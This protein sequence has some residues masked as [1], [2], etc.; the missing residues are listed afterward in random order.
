MDT[1][2]AIDQVAPHAVKLFASRVLHRQD[3][4]PRLAFPSF[5]EGD[6]SK[7][8]RYELVYFITYS[9]AIALILLGYKLARSEGFEPIAAGAGAASFMLIFPVMQSFGGY[10]YD[11]IELAFFCLF[12]L[13][14]RRAWW[15]AMLVVTVLATW[16]K[17]SFFFFAVTAYP[18]LRERKSPPMS[19]A[20]T[21]GCVILAGLTYEV[22]RI[23]FGANAGDTAEYHLVDQ[24]YYFLSGIFLVKWEIT[25]GV[26]LPHPFSIPWIIAITALVA[27]GWRWVTPAMRQQIAIAAALNVP[28]FLL[29]CAPGEARNLSMLF[30]GL[31]VLMAAAFQAAALRSSAY[32]PQR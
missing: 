26:P 27:L 23:R 25:Y 31:L 22:A 17:E 21:A 15:P 10:F 29:F 24:L 4:G 12:L 1:V 28:L 3:G 20:I 18:L 11:Y 30:P 13:L 2:N 6:S 7:I 5:V 32:Q 14:A 16:S 9:S 19:A 8:L